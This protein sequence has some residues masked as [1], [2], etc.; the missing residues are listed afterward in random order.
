MNASARVANAN[1][2][3]PRRIDGRAT[4]APT[5]TATTIA[6]TSATQNTN[7]PLTMRMGTVDGH[8]WLTSQPAVNPPTVTKV[9]CA[10]LIIPP[11]PVTTTKE[12]KTSDSTSPRLRMATQ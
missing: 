7:R 2:S 12:R 10:R 9:A 8:W 5:A 3:P 11:M 1:V 6:T 4:S